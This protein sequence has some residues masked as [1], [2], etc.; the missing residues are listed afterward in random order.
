MRFPVFL[1]TSNAVL[2]E[3]VGN[4]KTSNSKL[5]SKL[6]VLE[7][8][9]SE[10]RSKVDALNVKNSQLQGTV[11]SLEDHNGKLQG[12]LD[13]H[14]KL[15]DEFSDSVQAISRQ[16]TIVEKR[17]HSREC[18]L[19]NEI[20]VEMSSWLTRPILADC[21]IFEKDRTFPEGRD[22]QSV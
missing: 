11:N 9:N 20:A 5:Q 22:T 10:L 17:S 1:Q 21:S 8:Q 16:V 19:R 12:K 4:L 14:A 3:Q 18:K 15:L 13:I 6:D 7:T 2:H